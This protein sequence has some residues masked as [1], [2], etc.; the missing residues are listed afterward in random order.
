MH[1]QTSAVHVTAGMSV[2][3]DA[4]VQVRSDSCSSTC[5]QGICGQSIPSTGHACTHR[6]VCLWLQYPLTA[7]DILVL[8]LQVAPAAAKALGRGRR[9]LHWWD[10]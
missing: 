10:F 6:H 4:D 3:T 7:L 9:L 8:G 5:M 1:K 2:H